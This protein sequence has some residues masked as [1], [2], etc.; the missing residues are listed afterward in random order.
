MGSENKNR[1]VLLH[2]RKIAPVVALCLMLMACSSSENDADPDSDS[3][4]QINPQQAGTEDN[5]QSAVYGDCVVPTRY[6][7]GSERLAEESVI[8]LESDPDWAADCDSQ[9]SGF[10]QGFG[11]PDS[12]SFLDHFHTPGNYSGI[13]YFNYECAGLVVGFSEN[14]DTAACELQLT[15]YDEGSQTSGNGD[16]H[17]SIP[18]L[19]GAG[20]YVDTEIASDASASPDC[21][22]QADAFMERYGEPEQIHFSD[23]GA[24]A[25]SSDALIEFGYQCRMQ[26]VRFLPT[27]IGGCSII[28]ANVSPDYWGLNPYEP[29]PGCF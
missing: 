18:E 6:I 23:S 1:C 5:S 19:A 26:V 28:G 27:L 12:R 16:R 25:G 3:Q 7:S 29:V 11:E 4:G 22:S 8:T 13:T 10:A 9:M 14:F 17:E 2:R 24:V 20:L 15:V 21:N